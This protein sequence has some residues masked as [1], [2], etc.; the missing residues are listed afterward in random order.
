MDENGLEQFYW[1]IA[2]HKSHYFSKN[3]TNDNV[4][5]AAPKV[6]RLE[7]LSLLFEIYAIQLSITTVV[8]IIELIVYRSRAARNEGV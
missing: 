6:L 8:F 1:T 2:I 5:E 4:D 3:L 7:Q